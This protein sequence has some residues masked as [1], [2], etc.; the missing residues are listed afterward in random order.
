M[1]VKQL[2]TIALEVCKTLKKMNPLYMKYFI[3]HPSLSIN[4]DHNLE[5]T[6]T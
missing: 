4:L 6:K 3:I 1:E 5:L 2:R